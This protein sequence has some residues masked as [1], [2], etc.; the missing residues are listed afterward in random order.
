LQGIPFRDA[1]KNVGSAI[2]N[3]T[4]A[5]PDKVTHTHEGS[6]GNLENEAVQNML[7]E[8]ILGFNFAEADK[9]IT[10]LLE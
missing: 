4:F 6:I 3:G 5:A 9:A 10:K 1:Y 7:E 8:V 2:A